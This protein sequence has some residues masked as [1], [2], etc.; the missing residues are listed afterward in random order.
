MQTQMELS[1]GKLG[2]TLRHEKGERLNLTH[3]DTV[4]NRRRNKDSQQRWEMQTRMKTERSRTRETQHGGR[5]M[6][7]LSLFREKLHKSCLDMAKLGRRGT[8]AGE[9]R[10][11]TPH[12]QISLTWVSSSVAHWVSLPYAKTYFESSG[13]ARKEQ[14]RP[15]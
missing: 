9:R 14:E 12:S 6:R 11:S 4:R 7:E 10:G 2:E 8:L 5:C 3:R 1:S 13:L 15:R